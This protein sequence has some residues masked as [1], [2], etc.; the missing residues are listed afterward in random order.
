MK[1][2]LVDGFGKLCLKAFAIDNEGQIAKEWTWSKKTKVM[3]KPDD[4][5]ITME[6]KFVANHYNVVHV[7]LENST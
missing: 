2:E 3:V 7:L 5:G 4:S 6:S 1:F